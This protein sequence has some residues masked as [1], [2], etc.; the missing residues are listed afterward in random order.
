MQLAQVWLVQS[1]TDAQPVGQKKTNM[2]PIAYYTSLDLLYSYNHMLWAE[3]R[4]KCQ[5]DSSSRYM[6]FYF[7]KN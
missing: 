7:K 6:L 3:S 1:N 5:R 4:S 2:D